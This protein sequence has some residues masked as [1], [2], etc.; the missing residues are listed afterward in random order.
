M[1]LPINS[2]ADHSDPIAHTRYNMVE[3]QIRPW[4]VHSAEV[5][6]VLHTLKRED[7][8]PPQHRKKAFMDTELPLR[9][10]ANA[11]ERGLCM[12]SPKV[13]ARIASDLEIQP[14][15]RILEIGTGSGYMAAL[16]SRLGKEVLTLEIDP[17]L[18]EFARANLRQAECSNVVVQTADGLQ[19]ALNFG[20]FD[21]IVLSGSVPSVPEGLLEYLNEGGRLAAIVGQPPVMR[22]TIVQ[23]Q[24]ESFQTRTPWD[25]LAAPLKG[26]AQP[27]GFRF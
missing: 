1:S 16:L 11:V 13:Q 14:H 19:G 22:V 9:D 20:N 18:A 17:E 2:L 4:N 23:K 6:E 21:V 3:Q 10:E 5:I 8:V 7:F 12:L 15:E 24:D 27:S 25:T 26:V